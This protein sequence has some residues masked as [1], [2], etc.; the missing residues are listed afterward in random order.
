MPLCIR[1]GLIAKTV[2]DHTLARS[3]MTKPVTIRPPPL[4]AIND[5]ACSGTF[6]A[7]KARSVIRQAYLCYTESFDR[8]FAFAGKAG[9]PPWSG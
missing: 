1:S 6:F 8:I 9:L 4:H 2:V 5:V 3:F 7:E